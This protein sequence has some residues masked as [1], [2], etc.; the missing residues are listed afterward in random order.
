VAVDIEYAKTVEGW[1]ADSELE[2]LATIASR[3]FEILEVGCWMGRSTIAMACNTPGVVYAVD[4]WTGNPETEQYV[5]EQ[6][7][8]EWLRAMFDKN[9]NAAG[10]SKWV[11][12]VMLPSVQAATESFLSRHR[13]DL[14]FI[15]G[16]HTYE[17]VKADIECWSKLLRP[18]GVLAGHDYGNPPWEGV[19]KAVDELVPKFR[20][21]PGT[22]IWTTEGVE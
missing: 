7:G 19:I 20:I 10:V 21:V 3:S 16:N 8:R 4:P 13:F 12:P 14:I 17:S 9:I 1:M 6:G 18:N 2:Y 11:V 15:D 5:A 22:S